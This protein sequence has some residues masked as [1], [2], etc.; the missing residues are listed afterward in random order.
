MKSLNTGGGVR[1]PW[2]AS[3]QAKYMLRRPSSSASFASSIA[4]VCDDGME[5]LE[6]LLPGGKS[7]AVVVSPPHRRS[8][9]GN[10][11]SYL[12][13]A[14]PGSKAPTGTLSRH[15]SSSFASQ[16]SLPRADS[17]DSM[18]DASHASLLPPATVTGRVTNVGD[19]SKSDN[20]TPRRPTT[21]SSSTSSLSRPS[22]SPGATPPRPPSRQLRHPRPANLHPSRL[23]LP[24]R[25]PSSS[26]DDGFSSTRSATI[27]ATSFTASS[28]PF[29][30]PHDLPPLP[31]RVVALRHHHC[32][33]LPAQVAC[34]APWAA[35]VV[36]HHRRQ[37][38]RRKLS[39]LA[40]SGLST[41]MAG[42]PSAPL[43]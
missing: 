27:V 24:A 10:K 37:Q 38:R 25:P 26:S 5:F 29:N 36:P 13:G 18:H 33:P 7:A 11:G 42:T 9:T 34:K 21:G 20:T 28:L 6:E 40:R 32:S 2:S 3:K 17:Y 15:A 12:V 23:P 16:H 4:S 14:S 39:P 8:V 41:L 1:A 31:R 30:R 19:E 43:R 22:S 35:A